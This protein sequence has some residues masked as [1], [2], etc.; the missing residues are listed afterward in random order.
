MNVAW[1]DKLILGI[2]SVDAEHRRMLRI[3]GAVMRTVE[4]DNA[5]NIAAALHY[6]RE[7][8]DYHFKNEERFMARAGYP[9]LEKHRREHA[10]LRQEIKEL[11]DVLFREKGLGPETLG[12]ILDRWC[13][14]HIQVS[15]RKIKTFMDS[16]QPAEAVQAASP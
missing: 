10:E 9:E 1:S 15:D 14:V 8:A 4:Q 12:G 13:T 3:A 11:Q 6:L 2:D 7:Y 16:R 5:E